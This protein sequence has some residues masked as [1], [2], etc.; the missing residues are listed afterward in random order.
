MKKIILTL[1]GVIIIASCSTDESENPISSTPSGKTITKKTMSIEDQAYNEL[2][3][4]YNSL[5]VGGDLNTVEVDPKN[6]TIVL[7]AKKIKVLCKD[8]HPFPLPPSFDGY[9][10]DASGQHYY[11]YSRTEIIVDLYNPSNNKYIITVY[12][13]KVSKPD[14]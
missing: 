6:N 3:A 4:Q 10:V 7:G 9:G 14:C 13:Y 1:L 8:W 11:F 5:Q 12:A 2:Q